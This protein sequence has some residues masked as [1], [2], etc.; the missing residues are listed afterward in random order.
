MA[1]V[2]FSVPD[3]VK[4]SFNETFEGENKSALIAK[5]MQQAVEERKLQRRRSLAIDTILALHAK[6]PA[7]P[8]E[9]IARARGALRS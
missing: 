8:D 5:L 9:E 3:S 6:Q 7:V 4:K 2:N 1:T